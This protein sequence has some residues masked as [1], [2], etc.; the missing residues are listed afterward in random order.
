M[1]IIA[2]YNQVLKEN[3]GDYPILWFKQGKKEQLTNYINNVYRECRDRKI[4][5]QRQNWTLVIDKLE[6]ILLSIK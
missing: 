1:K 3:A 5:L 6:K 4:L 2:S